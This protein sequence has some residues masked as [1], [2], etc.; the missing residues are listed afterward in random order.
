MEIRVTKVTAHLHICKNNNFYD[1]STHLHSCVL[2]SHFV[3]VCVCVFGVFIMC[4]CGGG[5]GGGGGGEGGQNVCFFFCLFS[6]R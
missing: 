3:C 1:E 2:G 6:H 5:G 4:V